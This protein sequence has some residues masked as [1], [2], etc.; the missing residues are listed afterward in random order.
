[1]IN[2]IVF[3]LAVCIK[4]IMDNENYSNVSPDVIVDFEKVKNGLPTVVVNI[5]FSSKVCIKNSRHEYLYATLFLK[6]S[7]HR[8]VYTWTKDKGQKF[9][10][11]YWNFEM[12]NDYSFRIKN[13]KFNEYLGLVYTWVP[14]TSLEDIWDFHVVTNT[15]VYIRNKR[16][17]HN[18]LSKFE[19]RGGRRV[20][21]T[22]PDNYPAMAIPESYSAI[23]EI[24]DCSLY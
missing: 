19:E 1:M 12:L 5:V 20:V 24:E 2:R 15:G 6:E 23:W 18:L 3:K 4:D 11:V 16:Y 8:Y 14:K 9:D 13:T 7:E 21:G 10:Q 17:R 22:V